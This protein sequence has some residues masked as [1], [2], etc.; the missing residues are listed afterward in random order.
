MSLKN[1]WTNGLVGYWSFDGQDVDWASATAEILDRSGIN[2]NGN[3]VGLTQSSV[4]SGMVGQ[5]LN[6]N[7]STS[8]I[9]NASPTF[10]MSGDFSGSISAWFKADALA[11]QTVVV[12]GPAVAL[13]SFSIFLNS[14]GTITVAYNGGYGWTSTAVQYAAG[15]WYHVVATKAPGRLDNNT[16]LYVNGIS[17]AGTGPADIPNLVSSPLNIGQWTNDGYRFNGAIDEL[18]I[19]NRAL[20][21]A[22]VKEQYEV[23]A[24]NFRTQI[25]ASETDKNTG[26]L[27]AYWSFDGKD[28]NWGT[29][30]AYDRSVNGYN[31]AL[32]GMSTSS[33]PV[34]G[35]V[36]QALNFTG[37]N[38]VNAG[39]S[40]AAT[41][42]ALTISAWINPSILSGYHSIVQHT[43]TGDR[44][45]YLYGAG[46]LYFYPACTS[47]ITLSANVWSHVAV[48]VDASNNV[49]Y[50][51]NGF[52]AGGCGS[53][54][55]YRVVDYLHVSGIS[56]ADGE[57]F[58]GKIDEVR[59]Y[60]RALSQ[61]EIQALYNRAVKR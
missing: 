43:N 41:F 12:I 57:N 8:Y 17:V 38:L 51:I 9:S 23:T 14:N 54:A 39:T 32:Q 11:D 49:V 48:T 25:N 55:S 29:N 3:A 59:V 37:T 52:N 19:Y 33:S 16:K 28:M 31:G 22:E 61:L 50:Y 4:L 5:A 6:F 42:P 35:V 1:K 53:D 30:T 7:G 21:P 34:A 20:G 15:Q 46:Y 36:G 58:I 13:Q 47:S 18:R 2:N 26:G 44:A 27:V 10:N 56:T 45:F 40:M 60:N 24:P